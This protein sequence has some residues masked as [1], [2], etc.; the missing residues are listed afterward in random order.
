MKNMKIVSKEI[1]PDGSEFIVYLMDTSHGRPI[2]GFIVKE[3]NKA[4]IINHL[5]CEYF[6]PDDWV[7]STEN[8][9]NNIEEIKYKHYGN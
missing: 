4:K 5:L 1:K 3:V 2:K 8:L 6:V 9:I 7:T